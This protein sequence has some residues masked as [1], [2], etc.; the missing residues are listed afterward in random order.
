MADPTHVTI[1]TSTGLT[2]LALLTHFGSGLVGIVTGFIALSVAKGGATHKRVGLL[3][4]WAMALTGLTAAG[5]AA[6]ERNLGSVIAGILTTYFVV[7]ATTTLRPPAPGGRTR[8][9]ALMAVAFTV[10]AVQYGFGVVAVRSP[11]MLLGGVPAAIILFM[12]TMALSAAI[13]DARMILAGAIT[14]GRRLARHLWRM[15]FGLFIATGSFFLGQMNFLPKQLHIT[16]LLVGLAFGPLVA[17]LY[18][19]WRVRLRK[20][21]P[22]LARITP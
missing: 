8:D 16:P 5:I 13:G 15:C 21:F 19:L 17:L 6:Y 9:V 14:G 2:W 22:A 4:T 10:A 7:T 20:V 11:G 12:A 1:A 18:W 3:F